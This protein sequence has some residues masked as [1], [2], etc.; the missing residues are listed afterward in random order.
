[1]NN[2]NLD[3]IPN[4]AKEII[5]VLN[6]HGFS[7]YIVG[8]FIRDLLLNK[9]PHDCDICT[10]ATPEQIEE[11]FN[12]VEG[13]HFIE[14]GMKHGTVT[15]VLDCAQPIEVTTYRIDGDYLDNRHPDS[16][17][18]TDNILEDLK[19]RDFTVN[20]FAFNPIKNELITLSDTQTL[21]LELGLIRCVGDPDT[22]FKEDALRMLRAL[23][24][25]AQLNFTIE[26]NTWQAIIKNAGLI[27]N[28]SKERINDELTKLICSNHPEKLDLLYYSGL[29]KYILPIFDSMMT[30]G[31]RNKWH[32]LDVAHHTFEV[33][34]GVSPNK[35]M[36]WAAFFHDCGKPVCKVEGKDGW[37]HFYGH[38]VVSAKL[39]EPIM[40]DLKFDNDTKDTI[41]KLVMYHDID[42]KSSMT[43]A[44]CRKNINKIGKDLFYQWLELHIADVWAHKIMDENRT[45]D[46]LSFIKTFYENMMT[47]KAPMT[48]KDLKING[49]DLK[50]ITDKPAGKWIGD[51]LKT[52]LEYVVD[53]PEANDYAVL[54]DLAK[55]IINKGDTK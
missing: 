44:A 27:Q 21:D 14:T 18:F 53:K 15:V 47:E 49:N 17:T 43:P 25:A 23:R 35:T 4:E 1:M 48:I 39:A 22:R 24:F 32:Y 31:Q 26:T 16:V 28:I 52:L 36:R 12:Q 5:G 19:R 3:K 33:M 46:E 13:A 51:T 20:A 30:C 37:E 10:S 50:T 38:P 41:L 42:I 55:N 9:E 45:I 6:Q 54:V 40:E 34:K 7:A 8:G 11:C 29:S 2:I